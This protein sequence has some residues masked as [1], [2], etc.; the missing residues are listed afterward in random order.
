MT[1]ERADVVY[2]NA[3]EYIE[4]HGIEIH[5]LWAGERQVIRKGKEPIL[6]LLCGYKF[7]LSRKKSVFG[8]PFIILNLFFF[9]DNK[10]ILLAK[11]FSESNIW[12]TMQPNNCILHKNKIYCKFKNVNTWLIYLDVLWIFVNGKCF[13]MN[14][15]QT[16]Q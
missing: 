10:S 15:L 9:L 16:S 13:R 11:L 3:L 6:S 8:E 5:L 12:F 4:L 7:S 1:E 14:D 2:F